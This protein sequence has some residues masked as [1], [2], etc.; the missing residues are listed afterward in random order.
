MLCGPFFPCILLLVLKRKFQVVCSMLLCHLKR[1]INT[2][3]IILKYSREKDS[4]HIKTHLLKLNLVGRAK[5]TVTTL[6]M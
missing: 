4:K 2:L 5:R 6:P 3:R 1:N